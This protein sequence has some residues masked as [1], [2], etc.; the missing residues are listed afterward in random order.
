MVE[1]HKEQQ[2]QQTCQEQPL[3]P[4]QHNHPTTNGARP[5]RG[6]K[7]G[8]RDIRERQVPEKDNN[9]RSGRGVTSGPWYLQRSHPT[10]DPVR[11][12]RSWSPGCRRPRGRALTAQ[13]RLMSR[14]CSP[15]ATRVPRSDA[16]DPPPLGLPESCDSPDPTR[17]GEGA[18][19]RARGGI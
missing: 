7:F 5:K 14:W 18:D 2:Q 19:G 10:T 16:D 17:E 6:H 9:V 1:G 12:T 3:P 11:P 13:Q 15:V 4:P 8:A